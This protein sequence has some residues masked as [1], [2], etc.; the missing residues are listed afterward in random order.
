ML[1]LS[2]GRA[3]VRV[4]SRAVCANSAPGAMSR[5][6]A[7]SRS[8]RLPLFFL[9]QELVNDP[10]DRRLSTGWHKHL[11]ARPDLLAPTVKALEQLD[12]RPEMKRAPACRSTSL[13]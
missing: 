7:S 3:Q 8:L 6:F 4:A 11:L 10:P 2:Y 5:G 9:D 12:R 13:P 1:L